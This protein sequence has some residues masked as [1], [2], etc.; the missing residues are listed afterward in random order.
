[1][2]TIAYFVYGRRREYQLELTYSV[3]SAVHFL[4]QS[5]DPFR[6]VLLTDE[7]GQRD[8]LP[9]ENLVFDQADFDRWTRNG[10]YNHQ[11]KIHALMHLLD[12]YG[13]KVALIDTDTFFR[14]HPARLF[15]R[16]ERGAS[17]MQASDGFV[18]QYDYWHPILDEI[19]RP[20]AG[21][22][23]APSSPMFNSGVVGMHA[24]DRGALDDVLALAEALYACHPVFNIEQFAFTTVLDR[25]TDLGI[26]PELVAHYWGPERRH[27]HAQIGDLFPSFSRKLF[28]QHVAELPKIGYPRKRI[29]DQFMGRL[30]AQ[31][32][33]DDGDYQFAYLAY[34][35]ALSS[36]SSR[37]SHA[38]AWAGISVD[39][40]SSARKHLEFAPK[41]F[42][43]LANPD[44]HLWLRPETRSRWVKF[45]ERT[46]SSDV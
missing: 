2:N 9:V 12:R 18:G 32:R 44:T 21:F 40:L 14:Q 46:S 17:V 24:S 42:A 38:D 27:M 23:I 4:E 8:D 5:F 22:D 39:A 16:I 15:E 45:W 1:M 25:C 29:F 37:P 13:G 33:R 19:E 28:E 34:R 31:L 26:C 10:H 36:A 43:R 6:I 20:V 3:L 7:G 35:C 30:K 41:D 11:A